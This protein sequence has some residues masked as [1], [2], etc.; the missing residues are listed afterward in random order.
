M[1]MPW[2]DS[3]Q[4]IKQMRDDSILEEHVVDRYMPDTTTTGTNMS[5]SGE[6]GYVLSATMIA[7]IYIK[8]YAFYHSPTPNCICICITTWGNPNML[9]MYVHGRVKA[10]PRHGETSKQFN[11]NR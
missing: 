8:R 3:N 10:I 5:D 4:Y 6:V 1:P 9:S 11:A 7:S 2:N